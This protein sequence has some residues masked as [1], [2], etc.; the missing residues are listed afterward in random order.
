M[1]THVYPVHALRLRAFRAEFAF[2]VPGPD[3]RVS[4]CTLGTATVFPRGAH[5]AVCHAEW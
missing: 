5:G 2:R 1:T 3:K 4:D